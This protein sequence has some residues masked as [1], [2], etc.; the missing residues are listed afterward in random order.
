MISRLVHGIRK[1]G[2]ILLLRNDQDR[3][4]T[5]LGRLSYTSFI[6]LKA[7]VVT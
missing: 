7:L 6:F 2:K 4:K 5:D 1:I 3:L